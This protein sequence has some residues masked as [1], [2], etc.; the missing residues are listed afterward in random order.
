[1]R[2]L[3][4]LAAGGVFVLA[5]ST[6]A[7][8]AGTVKPVSGPSPYAACSNAGQPGTNY[9][10]AK[11]E[12]YVADNPT[13][14]G[15]MHVNVVGAFQQD[16]WS[17]GG[18]HGLVAA[19]SR[20][21][22]KSW[23]ETPLPFSGCAAGAVIDPF[24][25]VPYNRASDPWISAGP[26]GTFYAVALSA[27]NSSVSTPPNNDTGVVAATS[28]DGKTWGNVRLIKADKGT[29]P[30]FEFSQF[31][32]DK[33]SVTADPKRAGTAYVVWDRTQSPSHSP[34][35]DLHAHAFNGP[36]W[37]SETTTGGNGWSE[38]RPIFDP[39]QNSQ[40]LGNQ[41]VVAPN[42]TLY[43]F[44]DLFSTTGSPNFTPRGEDVAFIKSSDGGATWSGSTIVAHQQDIP[45]VDPNTGR[46]IRSGEGLPEAAIDPVTGQ[47]YVAWMDAR[48]TGGQT[49]QI[50]LS[51]AK[52]ASDS[53]W[54]APIRVNTNTPDNRPGFTPAIQVNSAGKLGVTYYD[55]RHLRAGDTT[56]L[57]TDYW[58][59]YS[60]DGGATFGGETNLDPAR[61]FDLFTAPSAGG[62]FLG[63]YEGLT[64]NG[65]SFLPFFVA[66]NSD[67]FS[68]RTDVFAGV[69]F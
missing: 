46:H 60:T 63:D 7:L 45:T 41:I 50:A 34:D 8:A 27:T 1:M 42:G 26:D 28:T 6:T 5:A 57:P 9:V 4:A 61:S 20:D 64:T 17:N 24:A 38:A 44:F 29:S 19:Y 47:L 66:T 55:L 11:D 59:S 48:F 15:T 18:A 3:S 36:T 10:N 58:I 25:G 32:N 69:G 31:F 13:T 23:G 14:V 53:A 39:G 21:G 16:R 43:D 67:N 56:T 52:A 35:A 2:G 22:G 37:F 12:P 40:T 68:N 54:S 33:E 49:D 65:S 62:L 30:A 51:T